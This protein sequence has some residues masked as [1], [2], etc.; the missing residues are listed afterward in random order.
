MLRQ[1][2]ARALVVC[3][4]LA[5]ARA[6][7]GLR[8]F[9]ATLE[10]LRGGAPTPEE[11]RRA[12]AL[13]LAAL[14]GTQEDVDGEAAAWTE[15]LAL[16]L[17]APRRAEEAAEIERTTAEEVR[18]IA[19]AALRP[20]AIRWIFSGDPAVAARAVRENGLGRLLGLPLDR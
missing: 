9:R 13:R 3:A 7:E 19:A 6:G 2:A 17:R 20:D 8:A 5:A 1:R 14:D 12:K 16:G 4:P 11:L 10:A 18:R 15:A